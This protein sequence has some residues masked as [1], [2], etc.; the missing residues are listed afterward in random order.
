MRKAMAMRVEM[1][2]E[3]V[4]AMVMP[5]ATATEM[6]VAMAMASLVAKAK[7]PLLAAMAMGRL[8]RNWRG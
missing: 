4:G 5:V 1:A 6:R 7:A 2:T 3:M 8:P